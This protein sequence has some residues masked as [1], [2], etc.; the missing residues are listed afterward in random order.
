M[1]FMYDPLIQIGFIAFLGIAA[2]WL[3]W[4]MKVPAIVFLLLS[5]FIAGPMLGLIDPQGLLGDFLQ[6]AISVAVGIILFE[7]SLTL[8]F[9]EVKQARSAIRHI[10]IVGAPVGWVLTSLAAHYLGGLSWPVAITFGGLLIVTGPTV[11]MPLLKQARLN[12]RAGSVLK[13]EGIIND[14]I[15]AIFAVLAYEFF[16]LTQ[17]GNITSA[18]FFAQTGGLLL[19]VSLV[20]VLMGVI[21]AKILNKGYVP[22]YMK[23][24]FLTSMVIILFIGCNTLLHESGL[25]GVT[26]L[27][28]TLANLGVTSIDELKRF[29]ETI[30]I[31]LVS[32]LFILLTAQ[33]DPAIL[34]AIDWRGYAFIASILFIVRPLTVMLSSIGTTLSRNEIILT[35]WIAPRGIVCAAVAGIMGPLLVEAGYEDGAQLLPLAFAIVLVTVIV[36]GLTAK[37]LAKRLGLAHPESDGLIIVG[38]TDWSLQFAEILKKEGI[39]VMISDRTWHALKPVRMANIPAY[40]G[41]AMSEETEFNLEIAQYN[42]LLAA[43]DNPAYNA[44]VC[45]RFAHEFGRERV[46]QISDREEEEHERQQISETMKGRVFTADHMDFWEF[47]RLY[48]QGWRFKSTL[49]NEDFNMDEIIGQK[50]KG[51]LHIVGVIKTG[52]KLNFKEPETKDSLKNEDIVLIFEKNENS[53]ASA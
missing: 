41:E 19:I 49:V 20:S 44:L 51:N 10:V 42:K 37:P 12:D 40:Y 45:S 46:F 14:P 38:A 16:H 2:Q 52:K 50:K 4:R 5:G 31:M 17:G 1:H 21:L 32:G 8:N 15:G 24:A 13:W 18:T 23:S 6:P 26:I 30:T 7:G 25:I 35:S 48:R 33:I 3:G 22:E 29:K 53:E 47:S 11:I 36:H 9:K 39:A 27:G 43:T 34:M 28:V